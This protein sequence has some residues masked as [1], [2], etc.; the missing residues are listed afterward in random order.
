MLNYNEMMLA[1]QKYEVVSSVKCQADIAPVVKTTHVIAQAITT[2]KA[3]FAP[4][5]SL[6]KRPVR[7]ALATE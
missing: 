4:K 5:A 1:R 2:I 3:A 7:N 6:A